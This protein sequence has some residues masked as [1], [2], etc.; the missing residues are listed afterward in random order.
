MNLCGSFHLELSYPF[1]SVICAA[2]TVRATSVRLFDLHLFT[3]PVRLKSVRLD[4]QPVRA[5]LCGSFKIKLCGSKLLHCH[6]CG[7][8]CAGDTCAARFLE[9]TSCAAQ[10]KLTFSRSFLMVMAS[11][12]RM[13]TCAI[14]AT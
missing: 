7:S 5:N 3:Q 14:Q 1:K 13:V 2:Q 12:S 11:P 4:V 6:L 8:N 9:N 10:R